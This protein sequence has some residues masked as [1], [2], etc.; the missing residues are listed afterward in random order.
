MLKQRLITGFAV[1]AAMIFTLQTV[2]FA[3]GG[4]SKKTATFVVRIENIASSDGIAA[5]DG[6]RYPFALSPGFFGVTDT[7][8]VVF[9]DGKKASAALEAQAEDGDPGLLMK[10]FLTVLG[11]LNLGVFTTPVGGDKPS[12]IFP[13]GAFEFTF[14]AA[15]GKRLDLSTM[16][17]QS[18]DLFYAPKTAIDL[19]DAKGNPLSGDITDRFFLWD[20]GTEVNEAPGIGPNQGPRQKGPN[21]GTAENGVVR[22]VKDGFT[23]PET[24]DVLRITITAK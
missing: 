6:S 5:Q 3:R 22:L 15:Q 24:R 17:G 1:I 20:A 9:E 4:D 7:R 10:K 19:F 16:Y 11:G 18:N 2:S 13:G 14:T 8:N 12:P 21:T 23:Y